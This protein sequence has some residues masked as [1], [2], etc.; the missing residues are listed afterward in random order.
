M[1]LRPRHRTFIRTLVMTLAMVIGTPAVHAAVVAD[2]DQKQVSITTDFNGA[3][4]LLFGALDLMEEDD[5]VI[6]VSGPL[7]NV[8]VRRK[9][10]VA[11][12]WLNTE[13]VTLVDIPS[14]YHI[15]STR[16]LNDIAD[17]KERRRINLGYENLP[18]VLATGS[19]I[20]EGNI[21]DWKEALARNMEASRLWAID[22]DTVSTRKNALFRT[23]VVLPANIIPGQ[24]SVRVIHFRNGSMIYEDRSS[25]RVEKRG[26]SAQIYD[27]AHTYAPF[28]G[29]FAIIFAVSAGWLAA[30]AF[31]R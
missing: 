1:T 24:Y 20:D 6:E 12:I 30:V 15:L 11:G 16:P 8:A 3:E 14:F 26:L 10:K 29:I 5:I 19:S 21:E 31:R 27:V 22:H 2:L 25:I 18:F 7:K 9:N 17:N 4:L 28:Y 23:D 13:N